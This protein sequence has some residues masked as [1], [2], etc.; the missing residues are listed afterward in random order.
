MAK[1]LCK[2]AGIVLLLVGVAGFFMPTL[3]GMHLTAI[4]DVIHLLSGGLAV[5]FGFKGSAAGAK[6]FSIAF[7]AVY[8]VVALLGFAA[9]GLLGTILGMSSMMTAHDFMPDNIVHVLLGGAF[10]VVGL[11]SKR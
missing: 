8:L 2:I 7:G 3:L 5:F 4:H 1:T 11:A 10:L 9:P 6:T